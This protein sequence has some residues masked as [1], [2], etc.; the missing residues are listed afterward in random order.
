MNNLMEKLNE[1]NKDV[2]EI[3]TVNFVAHLVA[4]LFFAFIGIV[5]M[6]KAGGTILATHRAL[7]FV[8]IALCMYVCY[9]LARSYLTLIKSQMRSYRACVDV[10]MHK[11]EVKKPNLKEDTGDHVPRI[12]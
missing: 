11:K 3:L 10:A 6:F 12:D 2:T 7:Y 1:K 9:W 8:M 4:I 5:S